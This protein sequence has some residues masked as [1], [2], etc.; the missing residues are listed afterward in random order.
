MVVVLAFANSSSSVVHQSTTTGFR[1]LEG[2]KWEIS[3][4]FSMAEHVANGRCSFFVTWQ[5]LLLSSFVYCCA[6]RAGC[7][8]QR[9]AVAEG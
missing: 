8:V 1:Q 7:G 6:L 2:K 3:S 4:A 5:Q 9:R